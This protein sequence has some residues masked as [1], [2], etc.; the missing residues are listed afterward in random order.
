[1]F[2]G[3]LW[4]GTTRFL[5]EKSISSIKKSP[6]LTSHGAFGTTTLLQN[7]V[8]IYHALFSCCSIEYAF[9]IHCAIQEVVPDFFADEYYDKARVA[10]RRVDGVALSNLRAGPVFNALF[11][12]VFSRELS[13]R[14]GKLAEDV[15]E[16]M[17]ENLV[18]LCEHFCAAHPV[19]LNEFRANLVEDF[20]ENMEKEARDAVETFIRTELGWVFTQDR[21][22]EDTMRLIHEMV[23]AVRESRVAHNATAGQEHQRGLKHAQAVGDVPADFVEKMINCVPMSEEDAIRHVQ[24]GTPFSEE[25]VGDINLPVVFRGEGWEIP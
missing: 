18:N 6:P 8:F 15:K 10:L 7:H 25:W 13:H 5:H 2:G 21:S 24:V 22:Y 14:S 23:N 17:Q 12:E 16:F 19:L 1:M 4:H 11:R 3:L 9:P 20:M